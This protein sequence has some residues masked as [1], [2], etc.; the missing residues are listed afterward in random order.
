MLE[1]VV[2]THYNVSYK[3]K[4]NKTIT[5]T[6]KQTTHPC[7]KS[8]KASCSRAGG[9]EM[10]PYVAVFLFSLF[11]WNILSPWKK[12][13]TSVIAYCQVQRSTSSDIMNLIFKKIYSGI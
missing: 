12:I 5:T 10:P 3:A 4:Q 8:L 6:T 9:T 11:C 2:G 13:V 7:F 1:T